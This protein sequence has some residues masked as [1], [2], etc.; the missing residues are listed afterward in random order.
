MSYGGDLDLLLSVAFPLVVWGY[1]Q[2]FAVMCAGGFVLPKPSRGAGVSHGVILTCSCRLLFRWFL[3]ILPV[4]CDD[5]LPV[6]LFCH[7]MTGE[8]MVTS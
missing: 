2:S 8:A 4:F 6:A 7:C 1:Y 5:V 3:G